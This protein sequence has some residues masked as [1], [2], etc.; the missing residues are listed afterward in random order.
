M[1]TTNKVDIERYLSGVEYPADKSKLLQ[2]AK[3]QNADSDAMD[4]LA[5][6]PDREYVNS[7]DVS[8]ELYR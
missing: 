2:H 7:S 5:N 1:D 8:S 6:L 3:S 4:M